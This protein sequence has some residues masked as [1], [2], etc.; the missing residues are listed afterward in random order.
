MADNMPRSLSEMITAQ[1]LGLNLEPEKDSS[2]KLVDALA[3]ERI[4]DVVSQSSAVKH[5]ETCP[6][7]SKAEYVQTRQGRRPADGAKFCP[8]CHISLALLESA[9][10][11]K[12]RGLI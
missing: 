1:A 11:L 8:L 7:G 6:L 9:L 12:P 4:S 3:S 5:L 2:A 10:G